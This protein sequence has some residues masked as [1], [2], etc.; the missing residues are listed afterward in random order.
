MVQLKGH[1]LFRL[2]CCSVIS[3]PYGSIKRI[4]IFLFFAFSSIFQ[5]LMVQLKVNFFNPI[6]VGDKFQFLMVQ[7]KARFKVQSS[8]STHISIP[9]GSIK[10]SAYKPE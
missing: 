10:S 1:R 9:Y 5:F 3:I 4:I 6:R 2:H 8:A 7:L